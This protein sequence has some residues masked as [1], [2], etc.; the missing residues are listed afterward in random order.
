MTHVSTQ[1]FTAVIL[2]A[3]R[4][5]NDPVALA[6]RVSC[7]ALAPVG[8]RPMVFRVLDTLAGSGS[9]ETCI[10]CGPAADI[11]KQEPLF[12][13][14]LA[15]PRLSW[16]PPGSTP[17][18]SVLT[19]LSSI[20]GGMPVLV[21]TA[22][23]ALLQPEMVE[24]FC[25]EALASGCDVIAALA[26][27]GQIMT[28]YP[29]MRRTRTRFRN[30]DFCGCNLFAFLTPKSH[31][32]A[33]FWRRV[34]NERKRPVKMIGALGWLVVLRYLLGRLS[35]EDAVRYISRRMGLQ[36]G[37]VIMPFPEAAVDVDSVGDWD[38]A[39]SIAARAECRI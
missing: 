9:I 23:H 13:E 6:A 16:L 19:A 1:R 22:D 17:S 21:T 10:L 4:T 14:R 25:R 12:Q 8:G 37:V 5:P 15:S 11:L 39:R 38:F 33:D 20:P 28:K 2:A 3:D 36:A 29:G 26:S 35:L 24:Y 27:Y 30:G 32:A 34:E 7:K 18:T 31:V